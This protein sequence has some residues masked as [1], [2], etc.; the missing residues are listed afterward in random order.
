MP[1]RTPSVSEPLE[2]RRLF[3][4][5]PVPRPDHVVIVVEENHS[6]GQVIGSPDAPYINSLARQGA[7]F[8]NYHGLTHP[9]QPNYIA[10]FSG[11]FQGV[12]TSKIPTSPIT[13]PS[14]GGQL[15]GAGLGFA[16]YSESLPYTGYTGG[17]SGDY[18]RTHAPWVSFADVPRSAH[19]PFTS[20]PTDA[21]GFAKLPAVSFVVPNVKHDMHDGTVRAADDWLRAKL[22]PYVQWARTHNS[23]L[24]VVTDEDA[25]NTPDNH[26]EMLMVGQPVAPGS[27]ST[28]FDHYSLLRC[29]EEMYGLPKL[30]K[31]AAAAPI[32]GSWKAAGSAA[33]LTASADGFVWDGA[34][35]TSYG[36]A[37]SLNVKTK[38]GS[39]LNRDAYFKF[40]TASLSGT[41]GTARLRFYA[42]LSNAGSV[43]TSVFSVGDTSWTEAGLTWGHRPGL[44]SRLGGVTVRSTSYAWFEVDVTSYV[45]AQR[46]AG[47]RSVS[48]A[49]HNTADSAPK[50]LVN[51]REAAVGRPVLLLSRT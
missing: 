23:L 29:V 32:T 38:A 35:T 15:V 8:T 43:A 44:G 41:L 50:V 18:R 31:A 33:S 21:A 14:L 17:A 6:Y 5:A 39:K 42:A 16:A 45:K 22:D 34:P 4:A 24:V 13:A 10:M 11:G 20:F 3:A 49:L 19:L 12:T 30:G 28:R 40:D 36:T 47:R 48:F 9:S 27:Y 46:A 2:S 25:H 51:S 37:K 26:V 1:C 7:N